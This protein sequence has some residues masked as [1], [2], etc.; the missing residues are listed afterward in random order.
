MVTRKILGAVG[1]ILVMTSIGQ[2]GIEDSIANLRVA[3][4]VKIEGD[5]AKDLG[6]S[7][8]K[9]GMA[10]SDVQKML[11]DLSETVASCFINAIMEQAKVQSLDVEQVLA[12]ADASMGNGGKGLASGLDETEL[13]QKL[14]YCLLV[15]FE[16]AGVEAPVIAP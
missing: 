5:I 3:M 4:A 1:L 6:K 16:G 8:S 2:A 10:E 13:K 14:K 15:A 7:L 9:S 11:N 12:E